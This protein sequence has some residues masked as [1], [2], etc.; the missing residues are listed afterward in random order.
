MRKGLFFVPFLIA[1]ASFSSCKP[2]LSEKIVSQRKPKGFSI[3]NTDAAMREYF[4]KITKE[5]ILEN[6]DIDLTK[7][8]AI[9]MGIDFLHSWKNKVYDWDTIFPLKEIVFEGKSI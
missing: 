4:K 7:E 8:P 2:I 9:F 3:N 6:A 1:V 5:D